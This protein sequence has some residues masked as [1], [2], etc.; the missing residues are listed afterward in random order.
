MIKASLIPNLFYHL[1]SLHLSKAHLSFLTGRNLFSLQGTP[2]LIAETLFSLN[3][4]PCE[5]NFTK[6]TLFSLQG[7]GLQC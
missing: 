6:E 1:L 4:F 5:K 7:I 3:G 2:L